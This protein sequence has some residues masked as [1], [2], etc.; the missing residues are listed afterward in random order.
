MKISVIVPVYNSSVYIDKLIYSVINQKYQNYELILIDDGSTDNSYEII[1]AWEKKNNKIK[2][3]SK[4]NTG[5]G[6]TR[7]F[8][9]EKSEGDLLF[10]VDSDDWVTNDN[11]FDEII[12]IFDKNDIDV[13]FFDREDIVGEKKNVIKGF[14][15]ISIGFHTI[16]DLDDIVRPGLG[17]K[18]FKRRILKKDMFIESKIYEDLY[19]TYIYLD[20]CNNFYYTDKCFYTIYHDVN[21]NTLSSIQDINSYKKSLEIMLNLYNKISKEELKYSLSLRMSNLF[22]TYCVKKIKMD[23]DYNDKSIIT[24]IYK[25]V[26]ILDKNKIMIAPKNNRLLK[27][28]FYTIMLK[29]YKRKMGK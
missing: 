27:K 13:L 20:K 16:E 26:E 24:N 19:T 29:I 5:P 4:E 2:S 21:S 7:K 10:F 14:E 17:T 28:I 22:T 25:V 9:F 15:N 8:G 1:K 23:K 3:Y 18:I 6:L 12:N 11:V